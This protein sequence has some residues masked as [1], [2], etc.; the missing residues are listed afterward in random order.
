MSSNQPNTGTRFVEQRRS[1]RR[2]HSWATFHGSLFHNRRRQFRRSDDHVNAYQD[3]HGHVPLAATVLII[4]LCFADAFFTTI[5]LSE[6]AV[7]MN[8][9]MDWL[10]SKN[11]HAFTIVK[12]AVTGIALIV[13]VMHYNFRIYRFIAVKY[14]I[15]ALIPTYS[16]LILYEL[17]MLASI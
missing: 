4:L 16:L 11:I 14:V 7:E 12:M 9:F 6:G 1:D 15:F 5:L 8:I 3:W 2:C 13:L 17:R 10:L